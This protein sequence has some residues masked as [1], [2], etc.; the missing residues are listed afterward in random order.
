M[1]QATQ[2]LQVY[3]REIQFR[4]GIYDKTLCEYFDKYLASMK[5]HL[6]FNIR[7][8]KIQFNIKKLKR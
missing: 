5:Q 1:Y 2:D 6:H 4:N 8:K 3:I 7:V